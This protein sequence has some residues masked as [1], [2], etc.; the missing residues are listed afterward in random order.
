MKF[1]CF[2]ILTMMVI[3]AGCSSNNSSHVSVNQGVSSDSLSS[4]LITRPIENLIEAVA[5]PGVEVT[6]VTKRKNPQGFLE[7]QVNLYNKSKKTKRFQ[8]RFQWLDADGFVLDTRASVWLDAS[9]TA[10]REDAIRGISPQP[11]AVDFR[12]DTRKI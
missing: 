8:Y 4:N 5:G 9:I 6:L 12:V 1:R 7:V 10:K 3:A 2:L 11:Q